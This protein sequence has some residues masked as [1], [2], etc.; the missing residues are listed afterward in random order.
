MEAVHRFVPL[1]VVAR[2]V[3]IGTSLLSKVLCS[4][5]KHGRLL[6]SASGS[7]IFPWCV[8]RRGEPPYRGNSRFTSASAPEASAGGA[9]N[10]PGYRRCVVGRR[11]RDRRRRL[12]GQRHVRD[13]R[14]LLPAMSAVRAPLVMRSAVADDRRVREAVDRAPRLGG[15]ADT[16]GFA[17][18]P[19]A[20][21]NGK[22][23]G[24]SSGNAALSTWLRCVGLV[25][26]CSR[27]KY[28][29]LLLAAEPVAK[30]VQRCN[31]L[32]SVWHDCDIGVKEKHRSSRRP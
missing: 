23:T 16:V 31:C 20:D 10:N 6:I 12:T 28:K 3:V 21:S 14:S 25:D 30:P 18:W 7:T 2:P 13:R 15:T 1:F 8:D 5:T 26:V 17:S 22:F 32:P 19:P 11:C 9:D 24:L 4:R 29:L 27:T